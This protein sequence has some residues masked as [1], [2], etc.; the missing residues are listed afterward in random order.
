MELAWIGLAMD[1][2]MIDVRDIPGV[3]TRFEGRRTRY[4]IQR[5]NEISEEKAWMK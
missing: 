5:Q 4:D 2:D 3:V 1:D